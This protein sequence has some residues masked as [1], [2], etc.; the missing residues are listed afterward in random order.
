MMNHLGF[1]V[2]CAAWLATLMMAASP[3][4]AAE[5]DAPDPVAVVL[6]PEASAVERIAAQDL[7]CDSA[8]TVSRRAPLKSRRNRPGPALHP[9]GHQKE[10]SEAGPVIAAAGADGR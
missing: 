1:S 3:A 4:A 9:F 10:P 2:G 8:K 7:D 6:G 5:N